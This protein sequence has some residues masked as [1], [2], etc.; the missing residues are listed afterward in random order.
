MSLPKMNST[1]TSGNVGVGLYPEL[2]RDDRRA[3]GAELAPL[4]RRGEHPSAVSAAAFAPALL[5]RWGW[6]PT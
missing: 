5:L 1:T 3:I 6:Y 4:R 2:N